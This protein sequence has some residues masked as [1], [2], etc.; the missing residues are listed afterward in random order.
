MKEYKDLK[1]IDGDVRKWIDFCIQ[2]DYKLIIN[3]FC[4]K[5][6]NVI[7]PSHLQ[8]DYHKVFMHFIENS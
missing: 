6:N 8:R 2:S 7:I 1:I 4:Y 5:R 3:E